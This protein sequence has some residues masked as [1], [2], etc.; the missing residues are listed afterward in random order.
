[1]PQLNYKMQKENFILI[2]LCVFYLL[3]LVDF[4]GEGTAHA[5]RWNGSRDDEQRE[6]R[7]YRLFT[8]KI[9]IFYTHFYR[10]FT[11]YNNSIFKIFQSTARHF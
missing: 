4:A 9:F 10:F 3:M 5:S 8:F 6:S 7:V 2:I 11:F 1:M